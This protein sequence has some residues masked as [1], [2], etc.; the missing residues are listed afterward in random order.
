MKLFGQITGC[1]FALVIAAGCAQTT[2]TGRRSN[3]GTEKIARPAHIYVYPFAATPSDVV[4][5]STAASRYAQTSKPQTAEE[6]AVGRKL[7]MLVAKELVTE[8]QK[9][10]LPALQAGN[11]TSPE[12]KDLLIVGYFESVDQGSAAKRMALGFGSGAAEL[13]TAVEGYQMT[14]NGPRLLGSGEL[15][16]GGGKTPGVAAP[17]VLF[18][19]TSNP[20]G[21]II[22]G[23]ANVAG[24]VTGRNT[25]EGTA[26]RTAKEIA[27]Q[28][29][30][31]FKE[32]GWIR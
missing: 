31:R 25:I 29:R 3:L 30:V 22:G 20:L 14:N 2:V 1:L 15:R 28:L 10:G 12:V 26:E 5:W 11:Q 18:A 17:L 24:E 7:G 32:Q 9:M 16:S 6:I 19:A 27:D 21:L 8:I 4:S 13:R 23:T